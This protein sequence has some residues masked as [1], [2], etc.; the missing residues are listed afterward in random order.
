MIFPQHQR[1]IDRLIT[2]FQDDARFPAMIIGGSVAKGRAQA[3]SDV[4][5]T[6]VATDEEY[7][8]RLPTHD[9]WY[10][11]SEVCDY[12][13]GYA[14]GKIVDMQF[15]RDAAEHGSEPARAAFVHSFLGY[16][17][18]P[19]LADL[20]PRIPVYQEQDRL[21]KMRSFYSQVAVFNWYMG[22]GEKRQDPYLQSQAAAHMTFYGGRLILAYNR[23]LYPYHKWFLYELEHA[24]H[25]PEHFVELL[26]TLVSQPAREHAQAFFDAL[27][28]FHDWGVPQGLEIL[29]QFARDAEW[30]WRDG[31]PPLQD[32]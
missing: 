4:D 15:L 25:K 28:S 7:A 29:V 32:W 31:R 1:T 13:G 14:E 2:L 17:H 16:S 22:D 27:T 26:R 23:V 3:E 21:A 24:E 30:N 8:R 10:M 19:E 6:L 20:L 12:P 11:S 5:V 18:L 9:L